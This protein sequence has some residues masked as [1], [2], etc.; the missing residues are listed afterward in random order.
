MYLF[1]LYLAFDKF[2]NANEVA[3]VIVEKEAENGKYNQ[4]WK[5]CQ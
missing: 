5:V 1:K 3:L 2:D 4:A